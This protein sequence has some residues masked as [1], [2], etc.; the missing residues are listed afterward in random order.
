MVVCYIICSI[1]MFVPTSLKEIANKY[2]VKH[3]MNEIKRHPI[4]TNHGAIIVW[5]M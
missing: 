4:L 3:L 5:H 1:D 2:I